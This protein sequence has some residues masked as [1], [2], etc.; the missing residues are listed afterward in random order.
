MSGPERQLGQFWPPARR[1]RATP[2]SF[3][4]QAAEPL[5]T[6]QEWD[7][8]I[9]SVDDYLRS[10]TEANYTWW[11]SDDSRPRD[12]PPLL[13]KLQSLPFQHLVLRARPRKRLRSR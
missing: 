7:L 1:R 8:L 2:S 9:E 5:F 3:A 11:E 10:Y 4:A 13:G 6:V 12:L